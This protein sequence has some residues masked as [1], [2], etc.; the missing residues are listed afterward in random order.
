LSAEE[1][2]SEEGAVRF[3]ETSISGPQGG[4]YE[5]VFWDVAPCLL[6]ES[7]RRFRGASYLH[8]Q[9]YRFFF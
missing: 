6:V 3:A 1:Y 8:H 7:Y 2:D 9:G 4:A 5:D